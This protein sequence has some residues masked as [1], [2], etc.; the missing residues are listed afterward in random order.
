MGPSSLILALGVHQQLVAGDKFVGDARGAFHVAAG[1]A[2]EVENKFFQSLT[3][4][5]AQRR[6]EFVESRFREAAY[7]EVADLL[8]HHVGGVHRI[9]RD[10][11]AD[12]VEG[13]RLFQARAPDEE[14]N[15]RAALATQ[16]FINLSVGDSRPREVFA[17][18]LQKA[19]AALDAHRLGRPAA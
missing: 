14:L 1:I 8:I 3:F 7:L 9:S 10:A 15:L 5:S 17:V 6:L 18:N 16:Q 12:D 4:Q 19:I 2:A 11:V 13:H